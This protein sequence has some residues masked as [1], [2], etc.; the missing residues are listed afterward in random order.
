ME[1]L[2]APWRM[3][4][5]LSEKEGC[6]FCDKPMENK[7]KENYILYRAKTCFI[8]MNIF[9]YNNGHLMVAPYK[10]LPNL[11]GLEQDELTELMLITRKSIQILQKA[12]NPHG[13]NV[14]MN[15]GKVAGAGVEEHLHIHIVP[16]WAQ[17]TNFMPILAETIVL[18]EHLDTTYQQLRQA[19]EKS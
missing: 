1:H 6:I 8:I 19:L 16:R 3:Q 17:D 4:Y 12:L 13:F 9:P 7:D 2:W 10:H 5:I 11:D 14:G 18:P 15:I